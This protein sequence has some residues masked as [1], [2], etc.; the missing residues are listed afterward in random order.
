MKDGGMIFSPKFLAD[1]KQGGIV[2]FARDTWQSVEEGHRPCISVSS[3]YPWFWYWR[4][5][6]R[7]SES[8]RSRSNLPWVLMMFF[9][10]SLAGVNIDRR[11]GQRCEGSD[12]NQAA[13]Q[14]PYI[15]IDLGRQKESNLIW[16]RNFFAFQPS[17]WGMATFVSISG[18]WYPRS[19]PFKSRTKSFSKFGIS[20]GTYRW[21]R[22]SLLL[23]WR[24]LKYGRIRL[25]PLPSL[26]WTGCRRSTEYPFSKLISKL[27]PSFITDG[28]WFSSF[29]TPL[30]KGSRSFSYRERC[31]MDEMVSNG[32]EKMGLSQSH[33][34]VIK[35]GL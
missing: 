9:K 1:L 28:N 15:W 14:D 19:S 8:H 30:Q 35:R 21:W 29:V 5:S 11:S 33:A 17:S 4:S 31:V 24:E 12:A 22:Q 13:F 18:G 7:L 34:S 3:W 16:K 27:I 25:R 10:T 2:N 6:I 23:Q 20:L 26:Q 32:M